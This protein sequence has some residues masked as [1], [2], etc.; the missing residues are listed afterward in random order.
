MWP[1]NCVIVAQA[2]CCAFISISGPVAAEG[3]IAEETPGLR[4]V[5]GV[6]IHR[7]KPYSGHVIKREGERIVARTPYV[8]GKQHGLVEAWYPDGS[9]R[10]R[11]LYLRG[12]REGTHHGYWPDGS[13]QFVHH[14]SDDLFEGE[15][16][17]Y[18]KNGVQSELRHYRAG[19]EDGQQRFYD[20]SGRL[21]ANYTFRKGK[22]Y[23]IVGRFDCISMG[24]G[25]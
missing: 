19:H 18:Y 13:V 6:L 16:V 1:Q 20:G 4:N 5:Q 15:Q 21:I 10:H 3:L 22:R 8:Q 25:G 7:G 2:L 14:Y 17:A 24:E 23:G 9:L 12:H 11:R